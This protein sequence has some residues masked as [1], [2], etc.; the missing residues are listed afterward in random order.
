MGNLNLDDVPVEQV[1]K[2]F[3]GRYV[4]AMPALMAE[5]RIPMPVSALMK[6]RLQVLDSKNEDLINNWWGN[7]YDSPDGLANFK[8]EYKLVKNAEPLLNIAKNSKLK[9]GGL[10]LTEEQYDALKGETFS[11]KEL[12]K[13]G[14]NDWMPKDKIIEHP[15]WKAAAGSKDL[16]KNYAN[17][18]FKKYNDSKAMGT[19]LSEPQDIPTMRALVLSYGGYYGGGSSLSDGRY[20]GDDARLVGVRKKVLEE[21]LQK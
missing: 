5:K 10:I 7:Y 18:Q 4:D 12:E 19:Y 3:T 8:Q 2:P 6:R 13:A 15:V 20:L 11:R 21:L 17:A 16:L 9:N 1:Y 14:I